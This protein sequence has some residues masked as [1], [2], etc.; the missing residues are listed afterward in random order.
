MLLCICRY[1]L[2][3]TFCLLP[4]VHQILQS[5]S[6]PGIQLRMQ[7]KQLLM[8]FWKCALPLTTLWFIYVPFWSLC[9]Y[10]FLLDSCRE[11]NPK[12][13]CVIDKINI[14]RPD[15]VFM[16][17]LKFHIIC[18]SVSWSFKFPFRTPYLFFGR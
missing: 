3:A 11:D 10:F 14:F 15:R 18:F 12:S 13:A 7:F 5:L 2:S 16:V 17:I 9:S 1:L 4:L 6:F 8:V